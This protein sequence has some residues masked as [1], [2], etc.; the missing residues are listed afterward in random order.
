MRS[1]IGVL[2]IPDIEAVVSGKQAYQVDLYRMY[3]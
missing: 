1:N 3:L 2:D